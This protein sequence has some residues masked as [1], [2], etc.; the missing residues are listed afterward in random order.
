MARSI[1][2]FKIL[3]C[4]RR[5]SFEISFQDCVCLLFSYIVKADLFGKQIVCFSRCVFKQI[6]VWKTCTCML[7][8][9]L[10]SA[11]CLHL[12][13][14]D[15]EHAFFEIRAYTDALQKGSFLLRAFYMS[16][17]LESD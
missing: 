10:V 17:L 6:V 3:W 9:R 5:F 12:I 11:D 14:S 4:K 13:L 1:L 7:F 16:R 2:F 8:A 15:V